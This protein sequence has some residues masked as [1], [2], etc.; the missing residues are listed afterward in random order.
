VGALCHFIFSA[1]RRCDLY[2]RLSEKLESL[3][4]LCGVAPQHFF[5]CCTDFGCTIAFDLQEKL[6]PFL[7]FSQEQ[8]EM[9][10]F[11]GI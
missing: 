4:L 8:M 2:G 5:F 3:P 9:Q 11:L 1:Q 6:K 10:F 7:H